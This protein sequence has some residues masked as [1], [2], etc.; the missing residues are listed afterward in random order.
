MWVVVALL[1]I[2]FVDHFHIARNFAFDTCVGPIL[3][4][5]LLF[6]IH[7]TFLDIIDGASDDLSLLVLI[8]PP[9]D[10]GILFT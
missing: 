2:C 1:F 7:S 8:D 5:A 10:I 6:K 9:V 3:H 4:P